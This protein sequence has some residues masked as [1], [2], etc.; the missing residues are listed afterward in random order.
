[1]MLWW[2]TKMKGA[3]AIGLPACFVALV[4]AAVALG[5]CCS[6]LEE[7]ACFDWEESATCPPPDVAAPKLVDDSGTVDSAGTFWP[8]HDYLIGGA[9]KTEPA[10]CCYEVT[11]TV[12]AKG[13]LH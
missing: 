2:S 3:P 6:E 12:C 5:G 4:S 1:M 13:D 11:R 7:T 10:Q 9:L 8:A